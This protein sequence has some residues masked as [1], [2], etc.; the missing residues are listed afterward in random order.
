MKRGHGT[1]AQLIS[2][3]GIVRRGPRSIAV[4]RQLHR[5][6]FYART[7]GPRMDF[8]RHPGGRVF[9]LAKP[10]GAAVALA[11]RHPI[12]RHRPSVLLEFDIARRPLSHRRP[13]HHARQFVLGFRL[14]GAPAHTPGSERSD[15]PDEKAG[16]GFRK[17][18]PALRYAQEP[19]CRRES[20]RGLG[21]FWGGGACCG[22]PTTRLRGRRECAFCASLRLVED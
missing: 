10:G 4:R 5:Q 15:D 16:S 22:C 1:P 11:T 19:A 13:D 6:S 12:V 8:A 14:Q 18:D 2:I 20:D 17:A 3:F 9:G 21:P 7:R